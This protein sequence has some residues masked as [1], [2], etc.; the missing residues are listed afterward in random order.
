MKMMAEMF[1]GMGMGVDMGM[2]ISLMREILENCGFWHVH[3][4]VHAHDKRQKAI[5]ALHRLLA[6]EFAVLARVSRRSARPRR[7]NRPRT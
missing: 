7:G 3:D 1:M 6:E 4:Q 2:Q 5:A